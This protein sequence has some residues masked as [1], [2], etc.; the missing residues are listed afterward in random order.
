MVLQCVRWDPSEN[1]RLRRTWKFQGNDT[2]SSLESKDCDGDWAEGSAVLFK[3]GL[4]GLRLNL[5]KPD[6][7]GASVWGVSGAY[8]TADAAE[9]ARD[10]EELLGWTN[11]LCLRGNWYW[12][13]AERGELQGESESGVSDASDRLL[14]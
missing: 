7:F 12:K 4:R 11:E 5:K 8:E 3:D 9:D 2:P 1:G 10:M 14:R 13:G 6:F